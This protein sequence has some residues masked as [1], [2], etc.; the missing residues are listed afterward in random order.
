[1]SSPTNHRLPLQSCVSLAKPAN[2]KYESPKWIED[3]KFNALINDYGVDLKAAIDNGIECDN[4]GGG[5]PDMSM[6]SIGSATMPACFVNLSV[7]EDEF[8]TPCKNP[9]IC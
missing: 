9:W 3:E 1:M 7:Q 2:S 8:V 6:P 5:E 4:N